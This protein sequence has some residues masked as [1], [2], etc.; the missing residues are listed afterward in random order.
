M[1]RWVWLGAL[2]LTLWPSLAF[3]PQAPTPHSTLGTNLTRIEDYSTDFAFLDVFKTS[4]PWVSRSR[5]TGDEARSLD[6]DAQGWVRSLQPDQMATTRLFWDLSRAPGRYPAGRYVVTYEGEGTFEY[7][8]SAVL[9][10]SQPGRQVIDVDP[11]RG[12][13]IE[14]NIVAVNP[15]NYLR[16]ISVRMPSSVPD[17]EIFN[18][19]F[20]DRIRPYKVLR[21]KDWMATD[22]DFSIN[23]PSPHRY[24]SLRPK[25]DD[26][27]W[28][29]MSGVPLEVMAALA[30][31]TGADAW[32]SMPHQ[33]DDEYI[34]QFAETALQ[35]LAPGSRVYV[36]YSNEVWNDQFGQ[37]PYARAQGLALDLSTDPFQAQVRFQAQRSSQIF[38]IWESVVPK[39]RLV[40]VL[41]SFHIFPSVTQELLSYGDTR[42]HT[43]VIAIAPYFGFAGE[44]ASQAVGMNLDTLMQH[45]GTVDLPQ[46]NEYT[47]Q[48]VDIARRYG[49]PVIA[50]EAGLDL[51]ARGSQLQ[52]DPTLN[53]VFDAANRDPRVGPLYAR[54]LQDW[55]TITGGQLMVHFIDCE[56][57]S[58]Y[59]RYGSLEYLDQ[60][61]DQAPKF[62]ALMNW[63]EQGAA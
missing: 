10:E 13:G 26:A 31:R 18:P 16:T 21:F 34:R 29:E 63:I 51:Q 52:E 15:A 57:F 54:Y 40:R 61:R 23:G 53:A 48:H 50:Y 46:A 20:V 58:V 55:S 6:L 56:A 17:A 30:N 47:R 44:D 32:F 11:A 24:W 33:A 2:V 9:V 42:A 25:V 60:P 4:R 41:S 8:G 62:D 39:E 35:L 36:E 37:A 19:T 1:V 22:G 45:L 12:G 5:S 14:L 27:R 38:A 43:D 3:V 28:S 7:G 49:L 59:G